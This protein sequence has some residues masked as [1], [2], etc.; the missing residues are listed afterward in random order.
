MSKR[1]TFEERDQILLCKYLMYYELI[2]NKNL[3]LMPYKPARKKRCGDI[4]ENYWVLINGLPIIFMQCIKCRE[5]KPR[6]CTYYQT[7]FHSLDFWT[8]YSYDIGHEMF[9][10]DI[11]N[12]CLMC[13][14]NIKFINTRTIPIHFWNNSGSLYITGKMLK[15]LYDSQTIGPI[16]GISTKYIKEIVGHILRA[17]VHDIVM[18]YKITGEK[19]SQ[20]NHR[21][22][23][24]VIDLSIINVSQRTHIID[25]AKT[26][27]ES[28]KACHTY[29]M[30]SK[31]I[32]DER[33]NT[34]YRLWSA[35]N[36]PLK[37]NIFRKMLNQKSRTYIQ[38]DKK[39]DRIN[40]NNLNPVWFL[41]DT[42]IQG[43]CIC[44]VCKV[45]LTF[46]ENK[47]TD[48]SFDRLDNCKGHF[49]TGNL[50]I[51]C[52]LHQ[53]PNNRYITHDMFLHMLFIQQRFEIDEKIS[54]LIVE[55]HNRE[56]C[57]FC[58]IERI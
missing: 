10:N 24:C 56:N 47:W 36:E 19:Y 54:K 40:D 3:S 28:Y 42:L 35:I 46:R 8:W 6:L 39:V 21:I 2:A 58:D 49:V 53:I 15:D 4:D 52:M 12:S 38:L 23:D 5:F 45:P 1:N 48:V 18:S 55:I 44:A 50:R 11:H 16:S 31:K 37:N 14:A 41:F 20:K 43:K 34:M 57:P 32:L 30:N 25:L 7:N 51:V 33:K 29:Y 9:K 13:T 22:E 26:V 17:S 27:L